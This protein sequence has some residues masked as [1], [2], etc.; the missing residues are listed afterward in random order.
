M[1]YLLPILHIHTLFLLL[2]A[3]CF[4][5][6]TLTSAWTG[7]IQSR[8]RL[9]PLFRNRR[10]GTRRSFLPHHS[11]S[12]TSSSDEDIPPP[13]R[14]AIVGGGLAGLSTAF[15]LLEKTQARSSRCRVTIFDTAPVGT[16]GASSVAGGYVTKSPVT[17]TVAAFCFGHGT[18]IHSIRQGL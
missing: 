12:S 1:A 15:H 10:L 16:A 17:F 7:T 3:G 4:L 14:I 11:F 9:V 8:S 5:H 2:I 6:M 18:N 13:Q